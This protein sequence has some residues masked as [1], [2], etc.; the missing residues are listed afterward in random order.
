[1]RGAIKEKYGMGPNKADH[2][3]LLPAYLLIQPWYQYMVLLWGFRSY[4]SSLSP[5]C[6]FS[7]LPS[8]YN[9]H[10][11]CKYTRIYPHCLCWV[12]WFYSVS[13]WLAGLNASNWR[14]TYSANPKW[15]MCFLFWIIHAF[16]FN[17][18]FLWYTPVSWRISPS[19]FP[20]ALPLH[21]FLLYHYNITVLQ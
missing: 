6:L 3:S 9:L 20:L 8:V 2:K 7:D 18:Y 11:T 1:M 15:N 13:S 19:T 17:F 4:L 5:S 14:P 21:C 12:L 16:S 10:T